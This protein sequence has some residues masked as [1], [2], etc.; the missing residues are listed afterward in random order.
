LLTSE[1]KFI[2]TPEKGDVSA[3]LMR[4]EGATHLLVIGHGA[5]TN[6]RHATLAAISESLA[7]QGIATFRY[8][9]PYSEKCGGR[10]STKTCFATIRSAVNAQSGA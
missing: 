1:S 6:M 7:E 9:F 10:N 8:N 4:P 3:L 2:A 5:S